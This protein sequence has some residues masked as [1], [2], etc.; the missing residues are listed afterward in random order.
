MGAI[1]KAA[2]KAVGK[3][4]GETEIKTVPSPGVKKLGWL[5]AALLL[6]HFLIQPLL[7]CL[8]PDA[9]FPALDGGW[10]GTV[11]MGL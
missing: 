2:A 9:E 10:I 1:R 11:I 7:S 4:A 8:F 6:W 3:A 5:V